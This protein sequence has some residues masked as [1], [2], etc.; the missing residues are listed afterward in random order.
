MDTLP[1]HDVPVLFCKKIWNQFL[2]SGL[3]SFGFLERR[4][5]KG[6][7]ICILFHIY[8]YVVNVGHLFWLEN[9]RSLRYQ[10]TCVLFHHSI[11]SVLVDARISTLVR[12][13]QRSTTWCVHLSG[14]SIALWG[15]VPPSAVAQSPPPSSF[16][17]SNITSF[18]ADRGQMNGYSSRNTWYLHIYA[19]KWRCVWV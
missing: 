4:Y 12:W 18:C 1:F 15:F 9:S 6:C 13:A 11:T 14:H 19:T 3:L 10:G 5:P 16:N 7:S 2:F 17:H 8:R